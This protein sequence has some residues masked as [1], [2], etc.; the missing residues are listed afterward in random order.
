[1]G[2]AFA[3]DWVSW[4]LVADD[5]SG[6]VLELGVE[7]VLVTLC[8]RDDKPA[9]L[10]LDRALRMPSGVMSTR[11]R[12][13]ARAGLEGVTLEAVDWLE[14]V[15]GVAG[16]GRAG[17][18]VFFMADVSELRMELIFPRS[19]FSRLTPSGEVGAL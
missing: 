5:E 17:L 13:L 2:F 18:T 11:D 14:G 10:L 1:M 19:T 12:M 7:E 16:A 15:V 9:V 6:D 4:A 3:V 8:K